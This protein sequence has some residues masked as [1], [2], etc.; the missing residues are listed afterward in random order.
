MKT[1][2][3][4]IIVLLLGSTM[5]TSALASI[6]DPIYQ[7]YPMDEARALELLNSGSP[8]VAYGETDLLEI[9]QPRLMIEDRDL[10]DYMH[11]VTGLWVQED[12]IEHQLHVFDSVYGER[13]DIVKDWAENLS[14][15]ETPTGYVIIGIITEVYHHEPYGKL[16]TRTELLQVQEN[17]TQYD[18]YDVSVTQRLTPGANYTTSSWVWN[19]LQYTMNGTYGSSNIILS[20]YDQ[21]RSDELPEGPFS[22]LWRILRFDL[23]DF[24]PWLFPPKPIVSG[25][26]MSDYSIEVFRTRY[27]ASRNYNQRNEPIQK[28]HHYVIRVEQGSKPIF[29]HQTQVQYTQAEDIAQIPYIT[30]PL[31]SGYIAIR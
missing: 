28:R 16:E 3:F 1:R 25:I 19:W 29:W 22:F 11:I 21:P 23:R 30:Q 24:F 7:K 27:Q 20:D 15:V 8:M 18:W 13:A 10:G 31:A 9:Y 26:D 2:A 14:P 5:T 4:L 12:Q 6:A 17:N